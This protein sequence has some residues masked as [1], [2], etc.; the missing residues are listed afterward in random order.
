MIHSCVKNVPISQV[1]QYVWPHLC[2]VN[3]LTHK[4]HFIGV[5]II[6]QHI[7]G[8]LKYH[9]QSV[10]NYLAS[11]QR[12]QPKQVIMPIKI[13]KD[14]LVIILICVLICNISACSTRNDFCQTRIR[15]QR[16]SEMFP[17]EKDQAYDLLLQQICFAADA[18]R[19]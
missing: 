7:N 13:V 15:F 8:V 4:T 18:I 19:R 16:V 12:E 14:F 2:L 1:L 17:T 9:I 11:T 10:R 3:S 5:C 6:F